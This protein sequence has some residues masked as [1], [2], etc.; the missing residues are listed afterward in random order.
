MR[1]CLQEESPE[2]VPEGE[3]PPQI[4]TPC[5]LLLRRS[6]YSLKKG[7]KAM[8][9]EAMGALVAVRADSW[10]CCVTYSGIGTRIAIVLFL[11]FLGC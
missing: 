1:A 7:K 2:E 9:K 6:E 4:S 5:Q 10:R 8:F 11:L 3:D